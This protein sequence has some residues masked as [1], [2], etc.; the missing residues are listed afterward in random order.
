MRLGH[1]A[2]R[3]SFTGTGMSCSISPYHLLDLICSFL[4]LN[5]CI[6][7]KL[8]FPINLYYFKEMLRSHL[9]RYNI[10]TV[11][12]MNISEATAHLSVLVRTPKK[13]K[14]RNINHTWGVPNQWKQTLSGPFS[15]CS[16][17]FG[18]RGVH[19]CPF[20]VTASFLTNRNQ[21]LNM[22]IEVPQAAG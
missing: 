2:R 11:I 9:D 19:K 7:A 18:R 4:A 17:K 1:R 20:T 6:S 12:Y 22:L 13:A 14:P 5:L 3:T 8:S 15:K 10:T 16:S 21:S